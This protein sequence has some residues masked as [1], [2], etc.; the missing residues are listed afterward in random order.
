MNR[1]LHKV[2]LLFAM[3]L[4][5]VLSSS[6]QSA[7]NALVVLMKN[8]SKMTFFLSEKPQVL[9]QGAYLKVA[10][11]VASSTTFALEDVQRFTYETQDEDAINGT[12]GD[13]ADVHVRDGELVVSQLKQGT[14][15]SILASDGKVMKQFAVPDTGT[16]RHD[17]STLPQGVYLVKAG[18]ITYKITR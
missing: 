13:F 14:M 2:T 3:L 12:S 9:F 17:L 4:G 7:L 8:G 11:G 10:Y 15:V 6:A 18:N 5:G 16:Y 1:T